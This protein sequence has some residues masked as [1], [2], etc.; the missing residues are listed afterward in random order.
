MIGRSCNKRTVA[1][2]CVAGYAMAWLSVKPRQSRSTHPLLYMMASGSLQG[3]RQLSLPL[4]GVRA[5][6]LNIADSVLSTT[7]QHSVGRHM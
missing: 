4:L 1:S 7:K 2:I 5:L 6:T 3:A